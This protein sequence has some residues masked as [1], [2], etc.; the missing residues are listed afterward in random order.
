M[1]TTLSLLKFSLVPSSN[2]SNIPIIT[3]SSIRS[4]K[5][6]IHCG[7]DAVMIL[8]KLELP[9]LE[10]LIVSSNYNMRSAPG[11]IEDGIISQSQFPAIKHF[12]FD[13]DFGLTRLYNLLRRMECL[14]TMV[15]TR[16]EDIDILSDGL[17]GDYQPG[18]TVC[19]CLEELSVQYRTRSGIYP[20]LLISAL[21]YFI[22]SRQHGKLKSVTIPS[23]QPLGD[24]LYQA[25]KNDGNHCDIEVGVSL[26]SPF[27]ESCDTHHFWSFVMLLQHDR[28]KINLILGEVKSLVNSLKGLRI[29]ITYDL[30]SG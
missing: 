22:R 11:L 20:H 18:Y 9:A 7:N 24:E 26:N 16:P 1:M 3:H 10:V 12:R 15:C 29:W 21:S 23:F 6:V 28:S 30:H 4:L 13:C 17:P 8:D 5:V 2:Q 25:L 27:G 14:R 19:P